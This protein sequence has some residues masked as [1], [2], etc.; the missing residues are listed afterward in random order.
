MKLARTFK[1]WTTYEGGLPI[2][3]VVL[4]AFLLVPVWNQRLLPLL[5]LPNDLAIARILHSISDET[6][7]LGE[8]Y[9]LRFMISEYQKRRDWR[10]PAL[11][12]IDG[13]ECALPEGAFYVFPNVKGALGGRLK[14][15]AEFARQLLE[16]AHVVVTDGA[17]FGAEGYIRI[18]Y[19]NSLENIQKGVEKIAET[20]RSLR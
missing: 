10:V 8:S 5:H 9:S 19:A 14:T 12:A 15:S 18:S 4:T 13:I 20:V 17:A 7:K 16:E 6:Y 3:W 2:V 1:Q 11:N